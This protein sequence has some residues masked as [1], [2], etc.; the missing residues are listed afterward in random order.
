M[1]LLFKKF[2]LVILDGFGVASSSPGNA[3]TSASMPAFDR[4]VNEFPGVTLQAAGPNVGLPWGEAGNS[5]VGHTCIGAGRVVSQDGP[6]ID[7][8]I[9]AGKFANNPVLREVFEH[10][11]GKKSTLHIISLLGDGGVHASQLHIYAVLQA[12]VEAQV[13][14][15]T[16]HAITDGRDSAPDAGLSQMKELERRLLS[17]GIGRIGSVMGRFYAMDRA[18]HWELTEAAYRCIVLGEGKQSTSPTLLLSEYYGQNIFDEI[19]PPTIIVQPN[20]ERPVVHPG[21][22]VLMLNFR[23]DRGVQLAR[24]FGQ[25]AAVPFVEK[26]PPLRDFLFATMTE[27]AADLPVKVLF[28]K[29]VVKNTLPEVLAASGKRQ[30][31]IAEREK[32]AHV[33]YFFSS[34]RQQPATGEDWDILASSTSYEDRYQNVPE[35]AARPLTERLLEKLSASYDF[36]VVNYAN[37]D[38][39]G[40]TGNLEASIKAVE[41]I[42]ECLHKLADYAKGHPDTLLFITSDHGNVEE[43]RNEVTG[44]VSTAHTTNPVPF[45]MIGQGL[46]RKTR[47]DQGYEHL[48]AVVPEGLLSDIAP[49]VLSVMSIEKPIDM[50]GVSLLPLLLDQVQSNIEHPSSIDSRSISSVLT[51]R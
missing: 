50:T 23:P 1:K 35:M 31:H 25:P 5:E 47:L 18:L 43:K 19:I 48:A 7:R 14:S 8:E 30:Y 3:I 21:D 32:Y 4:L 49:T 24:A 34:G 16:L 46:E 20:Q 44:K 51:R 36:Y 6:R 39:V 42:D 10:V 15:V 17:Y 41:V 11:K 27:Y 12:A 33:T 29:I 38:M 9:T 13:E 37:P 26:L 40:H 22:A 28:P 2:V 45:L